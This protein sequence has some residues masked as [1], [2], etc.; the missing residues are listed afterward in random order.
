[1]IVME[2]GQEGDVVLEALHWYIMRATPRF[3]E[4][5]EA[6]KKKHWAFCYVET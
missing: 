2:R 1:M 6:Q 3:C 4:G 5:E